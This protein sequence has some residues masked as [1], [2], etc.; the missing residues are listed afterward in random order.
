MTD[1]PLSKRAKARLTRIRRD[2]FG[3]LTQEIG[4]Y[5]E[6]VGWRAIVIG[7]ARVQQQAGERQ[8]NYEFVVKFTGGKKKDAP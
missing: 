6:T 3:R 7:H 5:L 8:F 4:R 2:P 1:E